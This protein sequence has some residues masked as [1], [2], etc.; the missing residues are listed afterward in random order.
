[1]GLVA[2]LLGS[3]SMRSLKY[4]TIGKIKGLGSLKPPHLYIPLSSFAN[5]LLYEIHIRGLTELCIN[6]VYVC[7]HCKMI[8]NIQMAL[9]GLSNK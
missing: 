2:T 4:V 5:I 1:M 6:S 9:V 7:I 3:R 8:K